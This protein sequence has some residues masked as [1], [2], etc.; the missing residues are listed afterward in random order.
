MPDDQYDLSQVVNDQDFL[1]APMAKKIAYLSAHDADFAKATP[2]KQGG[3]INHLLGND[4][5]TNFEKQN[6]MDPFNRQAN[7]F[8]LGAASGASGLP[9]TLHPIGDAAKA[10]SH[11]SMPSLGSMIAGPGYD[12]AK[13]LYNTGKEVFSPQAANEDAGDA[14]ARRA[15]GLGSVTGMVG[16]AAIGPESAEGRAGAAIG[17]AKGA[18][19]TALRD[20]YNALKPGVS[21]TAKVLGGVG[22]GLSGAIG[23]GS[24]GHSPLQILG[25]GLSGAATGAAYGAKWGHGLADFLIPNRPGAA[26][27]AERKAWN[28]SE[29]P[30]AVL[31]DENRLTGQSQPLS[32]SPNK[33]INA[34][35][36]APPLG[37]PDNPGWNSKIPS[38]MPKV[39]P[40]LGSVDNPGMFAKIP[41][42]MPKLTPSVAPPPSVSSL[43]PGAVS[44]GPQINLPSVSSLQGNPTPFQLGKVPK[45][46]PSRIVAPDSP[47]P[48]QRGTVQSWKNEDLLPKVKSGD[49]AA[50]AEWDRRGLPRPEG[51]GYLR[52]PNAPLI[53]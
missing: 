27:L 49:L 37:S 47:V 17:D 42:S 22:G 18:V 4:Q 2:Q 41:N 34:D 33:F 44:D 3:Y 32:E 40:E 14:A 15:H 23:G 8:L 43:F 19:G 52:E 20:E 10:M 21:T 28:L 50:L 11:P 48:G 29:G 31:N 7:E 12:I 45:P 16:S 38:S 6:K 25:G 1:N 39:K 13:G 36:I 35:K 51:A 53:P 46:E 5:E 30:T 9:E 24:I 26:S